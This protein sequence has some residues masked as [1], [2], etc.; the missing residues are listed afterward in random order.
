[1]AGAQISLIAGLRASTVR[2]SSEDYYLS[3]AN[4][5]GDVS[6][7]AAS[8]VLGLTYHANDQL[9]IYANYRRGFETPTLAELAYTGVGAPAFNTAINASR[10]Q[11]YELGAKWLPSSR[12]RLDFTLYQINSSDEI[13]IAS[14]SGGSTAYMN[15][16]GTTRTGW[17]LAGSTRLGPHVSAT[18]SAS[19]IDASYSKAFTSVSSSS[20]KPVLACSKLPGITQYFLF[21]E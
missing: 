13:V 8:P 21:S 20:F 17:E 15:A 4:G 11:H 19:A 3:N 18:V 6:Y 1:M 14:T 10:S 9:N 2:F 7:L 5:S 12:T 16:T